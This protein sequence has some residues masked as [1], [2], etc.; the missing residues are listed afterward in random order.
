MIEDACE[1]D[2]RAGELDAEGVRDRRWHELRIADRGQRHEVRAVAKLVRGLLGDAE[3]EPR[4]SGAART[5]ERHEA[6]ALEKTLAFGDLARP[7]DERRRLR[8]KE[9]RGSVE[10]PHGGKVRRGPADDELIEALRSRQIL[11]PELAEVA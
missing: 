9:R 6:R 1:R 3:R 4:L 11:E 10:A 7:A 8:R 2:L 5:C